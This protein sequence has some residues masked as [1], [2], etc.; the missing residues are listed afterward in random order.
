[1]EEI[2]VLTLTGD[3][4]ETELEW[5]V[6]FVVERDMG[7]HGDFDYA[8][9]PVEVTRGDITMSFDEWRET[10][11]ITQKQVDA[12]TQNALDIAHER[13]CDRVAARADY[14]YERAKDR[15]TGVL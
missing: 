15:A 11:G 9:D 10:Y 4:V 3:T 13:A 7:N 1:M 6:E 14:D 12:I 5:S 8:V 2:S